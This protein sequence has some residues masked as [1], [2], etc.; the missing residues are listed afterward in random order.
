M[1]YCFCGRDIDFPRCQNCTEEQERNKDCSN[2]SVYL[3]RR[4]RDGDDDNE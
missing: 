4:C 1:S 3:V 2:C